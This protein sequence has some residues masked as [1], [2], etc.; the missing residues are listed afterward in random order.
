MPCRINRQRTWVSRLSL[1]AIKSEQNAF[2]TLTY[3]DEHIPPGGVLVK[4][5]VQKWLKVLRANLHPRKIRYFLVGEY[6]EQTQRPH[7]HAIIYGV[8]P[9]ES[10]RIENTW[11]KG[12]VHVGTVEQASL[13][14][15]CGYVLKK[16]TNPKDKRLNG[17]PP[18]FTIMSLKPGLGSEAVQDLADAYQTVPGQVILK[19][20]RTASRSV[21]IGPKV[22][23]LGRYL[24]GK[25]EQKLGITPEERK[26][27][28]RK[29]VIEVFAKKSQQTTTAYEKARKAKVQQQGGKVNIQR[30]TWKRSI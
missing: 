16:M 18:E 27:T 8:S 1:E 2:I 29:R 24:V 23:P 13:S 20:D 7:Y 21:R 5:D 26:V 15:V 9:V 25:L 11:R 14:Y 4:Q 10:G 19:R 3:D 12:L 17:R 6:G 28:N 30:G 22:Y